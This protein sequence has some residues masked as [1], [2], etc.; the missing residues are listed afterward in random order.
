[1]AVLIA[2]CGGTDDPSGPTCPPGQSPDPSGQCVDDVACEAGQFGADCESCDCLY[3]SCQDGVE[4]DG[5]CSCEQGWLG[6]RCDELDPLDPPAKVRLTVD[7]DGETRTF[8]LDRYSVRAN[9]AIRMKVV[10]EQG[11]EDFEVDPAIRTYRGWCEEEPDASVS[12]MLLPS[13]SLRYHVFKGDP[14][15]D[16]LFLPQEEL[17]EAEPEINYAIVGGEALSLSAVP[18]EGAAFTAANSSGDSFLSD[19]YRDHIALIISKKYVELFEPEDWHTVVRKAESSIARMNNTYLRDL[20]TETHITEILVRTDVETD[21]DIGRSDFEEYFPDS[22]PNN[23]FTITDE[24]GSG[25]AYVCQLG[26]ETAS[27]LDN[28]YSVGKAGPADDGT[29]YGVIR[30]EF[31]HNLGS[32]HYEGGAPEG[33]TILSGNSLSRLSSYEVEVMMDCRRPGSAG[34][35]TR[36]A[37]ALGPY[38]DYAVPPYARL[39]DAVSASFGGEMLVI[40]ALANDHDANGDQI[41]LSHIDETSAL[42]GALSLSVSGGGGD[43]DAI[44]Y[45]PPAVD[46]DGIAV[47]SCGPGE[48]LSVSDCQSC[49]GYFTTELDSCT[50]NGECGQDEV[51]VGSRC[52]TAAGCANNA[53]VDACGRPC[54]ASDMLVWLDASDAENLEDAVGTRGAGLLDGAEISTWFDRSGNGR[55]AVAYVDTARPSFVAAGDDQIA[56]RSTMRFETDIMELRDVDVRPETHNAITS[57]AVVRHVTADGGKMV[58]VQQ[59][60]GFNKRAHPAEGSLVDTV[61]LTSVLFDASASRHD[62][63][64]GGVQQLA[65]STMLEPGGD[66]V[67][68]GALLYTDSGSEGHYHTNMVLAELILFSRALDETE[69]RALEFYLVKKWGIVLMDRFMY[70]IADTSGRRGDGFVLIDLQQ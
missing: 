9:G 23:V 66:T 5:S 12:A 67:A 59:Q 18:L 47:G 56:G 1:M 58:W 3:G 64:L 32:G 49:E 42:G 62:Y 69:R 61:A 28:R 39:D 15:L 21:W 8:A 19:A 25:L 68:L 14:K 48:R 44:E 63:W 46:F 30:H 60:N 33:P 54:P 29:F 50:S 2:A 16:W 55:D 10:T 36:Y 70:S 17:E 38:A 40:D 43:R 65:E 57:L 34:D 24:K 31:G 37:E 45:T 52:R 53:L 6:T 51:C 13:G 22:K 35:A 7:K 27:L 20:L 26:G 11:V 41:A 4:G